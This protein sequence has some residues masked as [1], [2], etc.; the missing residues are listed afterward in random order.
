MMKELFL[1]AF[2]DKPIRVLEVG[3]WYGLGSTDIWLSHCPPGSEVFLV[4]AWAPFSSA[5]DLQDPGWNYKQ[6]DDLST[7]A[8]LSAYLNT[9]RKADERR[10]DRV[11]VHLTRADASS[12]LPILAADTFDFIYLDGDHKYEKAKLDL[13]QAKRLIKKDF[14]II[15]GDDL[16]VLPTPELYTLSQQ[17]PNRDFL[18]EPHN[19]HPGVL[20][21]VYEEFK[22]VNMVNGFWWIFCIDSQFTTDAMKLRPRA[23]LDVNPIP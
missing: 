20:A 23:T 12:F 5:E 15:C 17:F 18:R 22:R 1:T 19:F 14:G 8:F 10:S 21:S 13:Q 16:E 9:K 7:D 6:V 3:V 4:D 11:K 2:P